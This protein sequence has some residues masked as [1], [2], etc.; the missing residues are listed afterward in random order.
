MTLKKIKNQQL[1]IVGLASLL[2]LTACSTTNTSSQE[3]AITQSNS[4]SSQTSAKT[5]TNKVSSEDKKTS[6]DEASST[7]IILEDSSAKIDGE[8]VKL[9]NNQLVI[10]QAGTYVLSGSSSNLQ[11]LVNAPDNEDVHIVLDGVTMTG[12][13]AVINAQAAKKVYLTLADGSK[14]SLSDS[15]NNTDE[16]A[17]AVIFSVTDLT[18]NGGGQLNVDGK[19][20]NGIKANDTLTVVGGEFDIT[21]TG[22]A[23]NVNDEL[24]VIDSKMIIE[25][26][27][28]A[29][30]VDND[31]DLSL[32]NMYLANNTFTISAG[33][34]AIHASGDLL[35]DSGT[36]VISKSVEG[37]EGKT[38][39]V[40]GGNF[41]ITASDD[42]INAANA[43]VDSSEIFATFNGGDFK[44]TM[45]DG[46][47]DAVDS[48]GNLTVAGANFDITGQSAFD[49][50]GELSHTGGKIIV[51]GEE[52]TEITQTGPG[53]PGSGGPG[54][55]APGG[56]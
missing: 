51:N 21:A 42:G 31:E 48:N 45:A 53:S 33:D 19:V 8:G 9:S 11:V 36:Y 18:I 34:D 39:T 50:D 1:A 37:L 17:D 13:Q 16:K 2:L 35:I 38:V 23:F 22:D 44:I 6:Y 15:T 30:K 5:S 55:R 25:A 41:D 12:D 52:Q 3:K 54:G 24:T 29:V 28:D 40:N 20:N 14:N 43:N 4:K 27:E 56:F 26:G 49:F 7:K 47:T 46:D 32:G 10:T